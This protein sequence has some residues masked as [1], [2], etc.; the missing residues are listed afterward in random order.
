MADVRD[1]TSG[2]LFFGERRHADKVFDSWAAGAGEQLIGDYGWWHT[3]G[4]LAIVDAT[5]TTLAPLNYDA[6]TSDTD[7][8]CWRVGAFG[9]F[10]PGG[11]N[12]ALVD[13]SVRFLSETIELDQYRALSTRAGGEVVHP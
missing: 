9:S 7:F 12:F 1:G 13:G 6:D 10:H 4:G 3:A 11:A 5:M 8:A 2:T